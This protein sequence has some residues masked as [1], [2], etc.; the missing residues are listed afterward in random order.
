MFTGPAWLE[1]AASRSAPLEGRA[2]CFNEH[3][4][5][6]FKKQ[7]CVSYLARSSVEVVEATQEG[8]IGKE[9][10]QRR[11]PERG[12]GHR[13]PRVAYGRKT[14]TKKREMARKRNTSSTGQEQA[15]TSH[16]GR[17]GASGGD[18]TRCHADG[19]TSQ[20]KPTPKRAMVKNHKCGVCGKT[21]S[22]NTSLKR[23]GAMHTGK[24][25]F[26]CHCCPATFARK[27]S[28]GSHV[29]THTGEKKHGC[30]TC[31]RMFS[32]KAYLAKHLRHHT[33]EKPFMCHLCP[34]EFALQSR[35]Q[36]HL[37]TH[38]D[39]KPYRCEECG[40]RFAQRVN[41]VH[42]NYVHTRE[43]PYDCDRCPAEFSHKATFKQL[44][45]LH[46]HKW[47]HTCEKP[48]KCCVCGSRF[49]QIG[50]FNR[51]MRTFHAA[52]SAGESDVGDWDPPIV[53]RNNLQ[54]VV[55]KLQ[56]TKPKKQSED[57]SRGTHRGCRAADNPLNGKHPLVGR[58]ITRSYNRAGEPLKDIAA[59]L[60]LGKPATL[61]RAKS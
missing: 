47:T 37:L 24:K 43:K 58:K 9:N 13:P 39:E 27:W 31:G 16:A 26:A 12:P 57:A 42:H 5:L 51:H 30:P 36:R 44:T 4:S 6:D 45:T 15:N 2:L 59:T 33:G 53:Q 29:L 41:L 49:T 50:S 11:A 18:I 7:H 14:H 61:E 28:L 21:L 19:S 35:L 25:P 8:D 34:A 54:C 46:N 56:A 40:R 22:T 52:P 20:A 10:V 1:I 23:H 3:P 60:L 38:T 48:F 17:S 32:R 55:G